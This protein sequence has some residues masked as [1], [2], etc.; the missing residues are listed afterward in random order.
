MQHPAQAAYGQHKDR[1][2]RVE[3][4]GKSRS[5]AIEEGCGNSTAKLTNNQSER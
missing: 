5:R 3:T 4:Q 1:E 2:M